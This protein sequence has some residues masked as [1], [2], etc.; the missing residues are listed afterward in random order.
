MIQI[1]HLW[2]DDAAARQV[3]AQRRIFAN[4][5]I[6]LEG[7]DGVAPIFCRA[8]GPVDVAE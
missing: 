5:P 7:H 8:K 2:R 1:H 3:E 6:I 4:F